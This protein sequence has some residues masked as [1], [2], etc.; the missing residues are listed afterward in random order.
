V[1]ELAENPDQ[2]TAYAQDFATQM[3][4]LGYKLDFSLDSLTTDFE[5]LF[6]MKDSFRLTLDFETAMACYLGEVLRLYYLG[7]W[8]GH[9]SRN[10]G[11]N[12]YTSFMTFG[13]YKFHPFTYVGYRIANGSHDTGNLETFLQ[14]LIPSLESGRDLK[15]DAIKQAN[16]Q[17]RVF[18][19]TEPWI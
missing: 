6:E 13:D 4:A 14:K 3:K 1:L 18:H 12:Y 16:Q 2:P 10:A 8:K 9:C 7:Q 17:G 15:K 11:A 19:D 5:K